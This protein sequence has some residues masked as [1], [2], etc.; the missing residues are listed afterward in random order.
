MAMGTKGAP[1]YF[2]RIMMDMLQDCTDICEVYIDDILIFGKSEDELI[3]NTDKILKRLR[4]H[5]ITV[6]PK[7]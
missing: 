6:N 7:S 4:D 5:S 3:R 2:Q 1:Q